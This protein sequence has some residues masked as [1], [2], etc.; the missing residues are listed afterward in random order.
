VSTLLLDDAVHFAVRVRG[1]SMR[2]AGIFDG[3]Y[4]VVRRQDDAEDGDIVVAYLGD[5]E[6]TVKVMRKKGKAVEL[7]PRNP[8]YKSL[9]IDSIP[10]GLRI[11]G[12]VVGLVRRI[13]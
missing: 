12:K 1:D 7:E 6:A 10:S 4:V 13:K 5:E 2:D 3:D 11:G 8:S 9:R